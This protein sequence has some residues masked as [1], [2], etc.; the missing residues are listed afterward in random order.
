MVKNWL[1]EWLGLNAM[2]ERLD[3]LERANPQQRQ[4]EPVIPADIMAEWLDGMP[5]RKA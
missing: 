3:A 5:R 2:A 1:R 4:T